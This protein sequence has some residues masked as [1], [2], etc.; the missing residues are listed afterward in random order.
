MPYVKV[1]RLRQLEACERE[2]QRVLQMTPGQFTAWQSQKRMEAM[3]AAWLA[4]TNEDFWRGHN[5]ILESIQS[6][7]GRVNG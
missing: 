2:Y 6:L 1:G 3:T 7:R 4:K 5:P